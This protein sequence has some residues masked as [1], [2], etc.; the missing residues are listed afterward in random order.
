M[1]QGQ[2]I[3]IDTRVYAEHGETAQPGAAAYFCS[4]NH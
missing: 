2:N 3:S 1:S 4:D